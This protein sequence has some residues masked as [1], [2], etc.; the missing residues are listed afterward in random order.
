MKTLTPYGKF[1]RKL[2][3]DL[4]TNQFEHAVLLGISPT[5]LSNIEKG[6]KP[7]N[8]QII[9]KTITGFN[10]TIDQERQLINAAS[11]SVPLNI[12]VKT[13]NPDQAYVT[14]L[15]ATK[16][17]NGELNNERILNFLNKMP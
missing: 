14:L 3:I 6:K 7:L 13:I 2:R 9:N 10:L 11:Q 5:F 1:I 17:L 16:L 15:F 12:N 8:M 4:N